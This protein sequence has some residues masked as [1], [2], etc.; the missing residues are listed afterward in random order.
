[1]PAKLVPERKVDHAF[2]WLTLEIAVKV[3]AELL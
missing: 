2:E 3:G 1:V